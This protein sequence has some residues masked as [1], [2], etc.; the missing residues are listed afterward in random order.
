MRAKVMLTPLTAEFLAALPHA[1]LE[2]DVS[3]FGHRAAGSIQD[4]RV[5]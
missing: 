1:T 4:W 2:T 3:R 5:V